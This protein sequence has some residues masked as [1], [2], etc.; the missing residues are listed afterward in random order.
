MAN[1]KKE[2]TTSQVVEGWE[3]LPLTEQVKAFEEIKIKLAAKKKEAEEAVS[4][5]TAA[6][7]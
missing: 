4:E 3:L 6:L 7:N 1:K 5:L 2:P